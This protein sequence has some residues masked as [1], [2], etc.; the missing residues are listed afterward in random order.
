MFGILVA[1][2][3]IILVL[4]ILWLVGERGHLILPSTRQA[5]RQQGLGRIFHFQTW[6][7][8]VYGRWPRRYI[9]L[10]IHFFF[11]L[12]DR[13]GR[14]PRLWW[15]NHYHGKVLT[16]SEAR[17]IIEVN[18]TIPLQ[19]LDRVVP[20]QTARQLVLETPLDIAVYECPCRLARAVHCEPT[21]V[22]MIIGQPFVDLVL[23]HHP[24]TSRRLVREEALELLAAEHQR[25]HLH[26]AWFKD[27]CL[28]RFF[29]ICNCCR[30]CCGGIDAMLHHGI[31]MIAS[32]GFVAAVA[33][34]LCVGCE[35]C[36][37]NCAFGAIAING[38][39][40]VQAVRCMGCGVCVD[41]C[42]QG[43]ITLKRDPGK[44]LPL[45]VGVLAGSPAQH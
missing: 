20:Y 18:K 36:A 22:C 41:Q 40:Q 14:R 32:S 4:A 9:G 25:G 42:R 33:E 21:Q 16:P 43:A 7:F 15:A 45:D 19:D 39:A 1:A 30:C 44:G 17:G 35:R 27:A 10:L 34:D 5:F 26:I 3:G 6:H 12:I 31:P 13:L 38:H 23:E 29:A 37:D 24:H 28:D 8:Y 11:G 2:A